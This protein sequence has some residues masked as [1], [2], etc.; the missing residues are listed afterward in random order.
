MVK[1]MK[2]GISVLCEEHA[3][4]KRFVKIMPICHHLDPSAESVVVKTYAYIVV[5]RNIYKYLL[6]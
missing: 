6:L 4:S 3:R 1:F 2:I 5:H